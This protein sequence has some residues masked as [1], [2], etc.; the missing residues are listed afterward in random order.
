MDCGTAGSS[1][2]AA[3]HNIV[4]TTINLVRIGI[5]FLFL[6]LYQQASIKHRLIAALLAA[7]F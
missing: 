5:N 7:K 1:N 3:I 4:N 6:F 2:A